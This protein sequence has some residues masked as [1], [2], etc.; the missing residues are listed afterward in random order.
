[1]KHYERVIRSVVPREFF[2]QASAI[3]DSR[4]PIDPR[5]KGL[6][7]AAS[8][9]PHHHDELNHKTSTERFNELRGQYHDDPAALWEID[10]YDPKSELFSTITGYRDALQRKDT[11]RVADFEKWFERND[12]NL[13]SN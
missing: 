10:T 7:I 1:M 2:H 8:L 11:S 9:S 6:N 4:R 13:K 3:I 5:L 12:P